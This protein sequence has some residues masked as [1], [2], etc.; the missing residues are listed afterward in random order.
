MRYA[1]DI[2]RISQGM[3]YLEDIMR[4][5]VSRGYNRVSTWDI[6]GYVVFHRVCAAFMFSENYRTIMGRTVG[7]TPVQTFNDP[8]RTTAVCLYHLCR[9]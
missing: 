5:A 8:E 4:Y 6:M 3:Q 9:T 1:E 7:F 2:T